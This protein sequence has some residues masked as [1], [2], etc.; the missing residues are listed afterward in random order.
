MM[1]NVAVVYFIA[2]SFNSFGGTVDDIGKSHLSQIPSQ[3]QF[4]VYVVQRL[5]ANYVTSPVQ[6][7]Q[8]GS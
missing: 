5:N 1:W 4:R 8:C 7:I 3:T 2:L 6:D